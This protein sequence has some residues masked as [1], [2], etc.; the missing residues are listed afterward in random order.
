MKL[1]PGP[2]ILVQVAIYLRLRIGRDGQTD[3][4]RRTSEIR[5]IYMS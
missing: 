3:N 5:S 2:R 4:E 1:A